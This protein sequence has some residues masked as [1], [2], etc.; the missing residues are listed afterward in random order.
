MRL[1]IAIEL[2]SELR[3]ELRRIQ[4]EVAHVIPENIKWVRAENLHLTLKFLGDINDD[5]IKK[6]KSIIDE[7]VCGLLP[8]TLHLSGAGIFPP[9]GLARIVWGGISCENE[10]PQEIARRLDSAFTFLGVSSD[11]RD[12]TPH[13][14]IG[15]VGQQKIPSDKI[16]KALDRIKIATFSQPVQ[17]ITLFSSVLKPSGSEYKIED[18]FPH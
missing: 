1:F 10:N 8:L 17:H 5:A 11:G 13:I 16:Q 12:F 4:Q 6:V 9:E 18:E 3:A 15:R 2:A 7:S 14:T